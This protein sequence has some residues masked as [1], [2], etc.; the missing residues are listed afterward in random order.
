MMKAEYQR[1]VF[2]TEIHS[3]AQKS[4]D[5]LFLSADFGAPALDKFRQEI[6]GQ[7]FHCGISEQ[8]MVDMAAGL[9]LSGKHVY[10]YAM[11][12]FVTL[13]CIEQ[14]KCSLALMRLPVTILA[15][16]VGL[17]YADAGPTHYV[18]EDLACMRSLVGVQVISPADAESTREIARLTLDNPELRVVRLERHA[19]PGVY[20]SGEFNSK[21]GFQESYHFGFQCP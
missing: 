3:A 16:G 1:D 9:A 10:V 19:L 6:P 13:R 20:R 4:R 17:G 7:F 18:T 8:H 21:I 15:V 11:A 2:I 12:P 14:I 5:I